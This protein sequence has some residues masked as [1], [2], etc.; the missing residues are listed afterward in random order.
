MHIWEFF[1]R[2]SV[3][4]LIDETGFISRVSLTSVRNKT[5]KGHRPVDQYFDIVVCVRWIDLGAHAEK[6]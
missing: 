5:K 6:G 2:R 4:A 3:K 1:S